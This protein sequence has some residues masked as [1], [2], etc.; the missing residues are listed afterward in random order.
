MLLDLSRNNELNSYTATVNRDELFVIVVP[1]K[2][3]GPKD[4]TPALVSNIEPP[5]IVSV[6]ALEQ[7]PHVI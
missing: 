3:F 1:V 4:S 7:Q 2:V 5:F 6:P